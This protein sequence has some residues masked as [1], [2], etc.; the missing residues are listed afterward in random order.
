MTAKL[1]TRWSRR[2]VATGAASLFVWQVAT[3]AGAS[4]SAQVY[5]GV[6]GFVFHVVF[7]KAYALVPTYFDRQLAF[8]RAPAVQFPLSVLGVAGL[9]GGALG[10][11]AA[12]SFVGSAL[13]LAGVGVFVGALGWTIRDN[14]SGAETATG[15]ANTDRRRVDRYANAFVPLVLAYLLVGSYEL[16][17][18]QVGLPTILGGSSPRLAHLVAAGA[19]GLLVFA[20]GFRLLPRFLV[21]HPPFPL[22]AIV[23][24]AGAVGPAVIAATLPSGSWF[25]FGAVVQAIAVLGYALAFVVLFRRSDRRRVGF[26]GVLAGAL[27]GALGV[28]LGLS[29]AF[30]GLTAGRIAAHFRLN[31]LGFLGLTIVGVSYQ[32]YPPAVGTFPGASNRTAAA[33]IA[34][35]GGGLL[36]E[37]V[38]LLADLPTVGAG[39]VLAL[40]GAL[41]YAYLLFGLFFVDGRP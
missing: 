20:V 28:L 37:V 33:S 36:V 6:F 11:P 18:G 31:V 35:L 2:F 9:A 12:L 38:G 13:W 27:A 22:V 34:L 24:P 32:F 4:R 41:T 8:P 3:L 5:L 14:L 10:G 1:V 15:Q 23:L 19:A 26:Y 25:R 17:A 39:Q 29:F 7:G 16:L 30:D 21:A 40:L